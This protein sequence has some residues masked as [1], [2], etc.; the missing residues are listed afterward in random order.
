MN[1]LIIED[2]GEINDLIRDAI[3]GTIKE[4]RCLQ[5]YAGTEGL[6]YARGTET[7]LIILDLMLPGK[8]GEDVLKELKE[9]D[10]TNLTPLDALNTL[11]RLQTELNNRWNG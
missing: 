4:A 10:I 5:A 3:S 11:Y 2:N 9:I 6:L 1:I 7:D 8:S